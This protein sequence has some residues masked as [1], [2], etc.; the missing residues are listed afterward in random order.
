V[1][2]Q[3][4]AKIKKWLISNSSSPLLQRVCEFAF[5][6]H[7]YCYLKSLRQYLQGRDFLLNTMSLYFWRPGVCLCLF[8]CAYVAMEGK[9]HIVALFEEIRPKPLY[10]ISLYWIPKSLPPSES[11]HETQLGTKA[12]ACLQSFICSMKYLWESCPVCD[13]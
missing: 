13:V 6:M 8:M 9:S 5:L 7:C 10:G 3:E 12:T 4:N 1:H 2:L 11:H